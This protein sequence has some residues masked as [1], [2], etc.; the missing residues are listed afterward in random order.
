MVKSA[1]VYAQK[2]LEAFPAH[3]DAIINRFIR[4]ALWMHL[5]A[6]Q[7]GTVKRDITPLLDGLRRYM[8]W[9]RNLRT[10]FAI[11]LLRTR[12]DKH[13]DLKRL[14]GFTPAPAPSGAS[15]PADVELAAKSVQNLSAV[16]Y[17]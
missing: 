10:L 15:Q 1:T 4:V 9:R 8:P 14:L 17:D 7:Q 5:E 16:L 11:L 13:F 12:Q 3:R 6:P 2:S